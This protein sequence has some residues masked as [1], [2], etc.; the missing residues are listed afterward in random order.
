[1]KKNILIRSVGGGLPEKR[2]SNDDISKLVDTSDEWIY[3]RTG[4]RSRRIAGAHEA[5]SDLATQAARMAIERA[6]WT[7]ESVDLVVLATMSPDYFGVPATACI[8]QHNIGAV[9]AA[10][11]DVTA[12]C[13][14]FIYG[15]TMV[16][17]MLM[18]GPWK[19]AVVI[20]AEVLTR[21]VDWTDR[22]TCV[23][24][25][26]GAGAVAVEAVPAGHDSRGL[27]N[28]HI[29]SDGSGYESI[30]V[31]NGGSRHPLQEGQPGKPLVLE[32]MGKKVYSFAVD[33]LPRVV[34]QLMEQAH[35]T[36]D[37]ITYI[38]PH[39]ANA[40]IINTAAEKLG[41]DISKFFMNVDEYANT[42]AASI[43]LALYDMDQRGLLKPGNLIIGVGFGAGLTYGG[44]LFRW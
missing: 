4:I 3:T 24:F 1:M 41:M 35:I 6:G 5:T 2:V 36:A 12:A 13:S 9:N 38:V 34:R 39:Q 28:F 11:F 29:G 21:F 22:N 19:R 40:R 18:T 15:L 26:D 30:M 42:S 33:I 7:P 14:G 32:M 23:L 10:A 25:G 16:N 44:V 37:D 8:V 20:G 31:R 43:P 27:L 17:S